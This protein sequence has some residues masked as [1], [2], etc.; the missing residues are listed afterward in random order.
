MMFRCFGDHRFGC[1]KQSDLL[2]PELKSGIPNAHIQQTRAGGAPE[3]QPSLW[4]RT[5]G[6]L[7]PREVYFLYHLLI[8]VLPFVNFMNIFSISLPLRLWHSPRQRTPL[9]CNLVSTVL[10]HV[11]A[12][13]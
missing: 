3:I 12:Q 13:P 2:K 9:G 10:M 1:R 6:R 11:G 5:S 8:F 7:L 4:F